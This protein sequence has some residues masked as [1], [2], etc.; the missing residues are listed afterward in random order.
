MRRHRP[1][2]ETAFHSWSRRVSPSRRNPSGSDMRTS[3]L[4]RVLAVA[5]AASLALAACSD[6]TNTPT[7]SGTSA[8]P[9]AQSGS[10]A[11]PSSDTGASS[12]A[13]GGASASAPAG[14]G[15][16]SARPTT[17]CAMPR[18][19][20]PVPSSSSGCRPGLI[21]R[22]GS[23]RSARHDRPDRPDQHDRHDRLHRALRR[24]KCGDRSTYCDVAQNDAA[25]TA[26]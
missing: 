17:C 26:T 15:S 12:S 13:G 22:P 1:L 8:A 25:L 20:S 7:S 6:P 11:A 21:P 5:A 4:V 9:P 14:S 19:S 3:R 23:R 10:S 16:A 18:P 24:S 2:G